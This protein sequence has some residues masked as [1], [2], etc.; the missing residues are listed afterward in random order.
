MSHVMFGLEFELGQS[1]Y[2]QRLI[3]NVENCYFQSTGDA[4]TQIFNTTI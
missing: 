4:S 1:V 3:E 2:Y